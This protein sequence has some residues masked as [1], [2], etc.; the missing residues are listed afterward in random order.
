MKIVILDGYGLN[1]GDLSWSQLETLGDVVVYPRTAPED[2]EERSKDAEIILTNKV[3]FSDATISKLKKLKYIGVLAT[4]YN[5]VDVKAASSKGIIVTNIPSYS[6]DSVAQMTFAHILNITN[7]IGHYAEENR[8][9]RWSSNPDFCYWDNDL[10]ELSGKTIGIVGLGNI[11]LRVARIAR[12]FGMDVFAYTSKNKADLPDGIQKTTLEGLYG[13]SDILTLH[14]PLTAGTKEFINKNTISKMKHG[15]ILI[16]TG[17][18]QLVNEQDVANALKSG[19]LG[20]YGA[21]VLCKEPPSIDNPLLKAPNAF[22]TPHI[23]WATKDARLRLLSI[24]VNNLK[25]FIANKP[26]NIVK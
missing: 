26:V 21:D 3:V 14:C 23:A 10:M 19:Q 11:G 13:I 22:I 12:D 24:A 8:K 1:P 18:G 5:I 2:V 4:G 17:R 16:N 25:C 6:T 7:R 15:A 9:G 20:G